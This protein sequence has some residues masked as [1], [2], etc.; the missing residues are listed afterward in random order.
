MDG[1][2]PDARRFRAVLGAAIERS[3]RASDHSTVRAFV[4][5][6]DVLWA[7]GNRD[8]A[9]RV[10]ECWNELGR[11]H[12][13]SL[14]C[15]YAMGNFSD[16]AQTQPFRD[17][18]RQHTHVVPTERLAQTHGDERLVEISVLQQRAQALEAEIAHCKELEQQLRETLAERRRMEEVLR[19]REHELSSANMKLQAAGDAN[20]MLYRHLVE[21]VQ[22]YAI[23]MLDPH[24]R[25][26]SWNDGAERI[27]GYA[28]GE[29]IGQ[30]FSVFFPAEDVARGKPVWELEAAARDGRVEDEGWRVRKDG[31][32]FWANVV[33][34]ALHDDAGGLTGFAKI[35]RDM[36]E[37]RA[38]EER[39]IEDARLVAESNAANNAK[40]QFLAVMSH[41][42]RTPLNAIG[43]YVQLI[44]MGVHGPVNEAQR[45]ALERVQ[46][47]QRHLLS[48]INDMLNLVRIEAGHVDFALED[49]EM[50]PL[51]AGVIT[52]IEPLVSAKRLTCEVATPRAGD[53]EPA[54]VVCVDREKVQQI[55]LNLL[56]NA[57]KFT[58]AGGRVTV[59]VARAPDDPAMAH[60]L[61]RD[62][63]IGI[64][65]AKLESIFEPFVQLGTRPAAK[66]A[67]VGLGLAISRD[68]AR[69]M[70][71]D[72]TAIS[73]VGEGT[74]FTLTLPVA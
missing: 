68:L 30:H 32:R 24:G 74:T 69:G 21:S 51:L 4:G 48:L 72:I 60:V 37:R 73:T 31:S 56:T 36:T 64:P 7:D 49:V 19:Q 71:G 47:S 59:E 62:T 13:L 44:E 41:E 58:P 18:C 43:G 33:L 15:A 61:V 52:M 26:L 20:G 25:V 57:I 65:A 12:A 53:S 67:G 35:T 50:G 22:D 16:E 34:T 8:G 42:L 38:A 40:S 54:I 23:F 28:A 3:R 63:G 9:I 14:L 45:D 1:S 46:R 2:V 11:T 29:I 17:I 66:D 10:E 27:K 70:G 39:A 5:M 6:V 55:L